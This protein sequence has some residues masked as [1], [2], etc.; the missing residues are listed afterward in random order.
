MVLFIPVAASWLSEMRQCR[1][2]DSDK[3]ESLLL[4]G[5]YGCV[6]SAKVAVRL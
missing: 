1:K 2:S 6:S 4:M 5:E 3:L